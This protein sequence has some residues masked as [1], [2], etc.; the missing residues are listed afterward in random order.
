M[1]S[2]DHQPRL[3]EDVLFLA[4]TRP[5]MF[6]GAPMEAVGLNIVASTSV[7]LGVHSLLALAI[8]PVLHL[9]AAGIC[10]SEPNAFRLAY[11]WAETKARARNR[12]LWGAS[13]I[14]PLP[15]RKLARKGSGRE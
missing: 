11:L 12:A 3:V 8:A 1:T 9:V 6:A 14:S 13:S 4:C 7:F 15:F 5:A 10:R 2:A